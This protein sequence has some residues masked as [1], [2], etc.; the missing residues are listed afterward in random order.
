[1]QLSKFPALLLLHYAIV[2]P[3]RKSG[4]ERTPGRSKPELVMIERPIFLGAETL[5]REA[6]QRQ[7]CDGD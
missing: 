3:Q 1:M 2:R 5:P 6:Q 4:K 7:Q